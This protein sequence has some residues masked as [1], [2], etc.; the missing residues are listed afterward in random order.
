MLRIFEKLYI[1]IFFVCSSY[2]QSNNREFIFYDWGKQFGYVN[3][4]GMIRWGQD[5]EANNLLFDGSWAIF[6]PMFGEEIENSFQISPGIKVNADSI[7]TTSKINYHQ[8][9]YGL[10]KFSLIID[11]IEENRSIKLRG[12]KRSYFGNNNQ[13][14]ANT[15]QP[16]QQSYTLAITSFE[17]NQNTGL[18][19]GHFNTFSGLPDS[20]INGLFDNRITSLNYFYQKVFDNISI[21]IST[22]QFLQ[23]YLSNHNLSF[24]KKSRYLNRSA[25]EIE[26]SNLEER[27]PISSVS[28]KSNNRVTVLD[29]TVHIDW[30]TLHSDFRF[31]PFIIYNQLIKYGDEIFHDYDLVY[32][33][34]MTFFNIFLSR[35]ISHILLHPY[36]LHKQNSDN[37]NKFYKIII[38]KGVAEWMG[39]NS[40]IALDISYTTDQQKLAMESLEKKNQYSSIMLTVSKKFNSTMNASLNYNIMDTENY[41][42]GGIGNHIS[43][44]IESKFQ[45]FENFMKVELDTEIRHL[46]NR[47]NHS[48]INP[49]EMVPMIIFKN[50]YRQLKPV[51]LMNAALRA[52]VSTV[53][54]EFQWINLSEIILSTLQAKK[55]NSILIHPSMPYLGRQ[56]KFSINWEF[57]D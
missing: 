7:K 38:N 27:V 56:I 35:K 31:K 30:V 6:P 26:F 45:L 47:V 41:Y 53:L 3:E 52:K 5:W 42:S 29:S 49:V 48:M 23:R 25:Y 11:Y 22:D 33:R 28:F 4:N 40:R 10:D 51:N 39:V 8:G 43:L 13:Y 24:Y 1:L 34:H 54:F 15:L 16:Q 55:N 12:F 37:H 44:K 9:D 32:N 46:F 50:D 14:Y 57:R 2:C 20:T 36:Y 18:S 17:D 19:I 21:K